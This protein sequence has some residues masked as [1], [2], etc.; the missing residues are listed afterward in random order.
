MA[1]LNYPNGTVPIT[2]YEE[3]SP[4]IKF[5][6]MYDS[7]VDDDAQ[8]YTIACSAEMSP[9]KAPSWMWNV[10]L[11]RET[12]KNGKVPYSGG[13]SLSLFSPGVDYY[14]DI[15]YNIDGEIFYEGSRKF[16]IPEEPVT[17][18]STEEVEESESGTSNNS[19]LAKKLE[20]A[21]NNNITP[22]EGGTDST[23][24]AKEM[25]AAIEEFISKQEFRIVKMNPPLDVKRIKTD[26]DVVGS[27]TPETTAGPTGLMMSKV[28]P[29]LNSLTGGAF[30]KLV[31]IVELA[32]KKADLGSDGVKVPI[33]LKSNAGLDSPEGKL[34]VEGQAVIDTPYEGKSTSQGY[35]SHTVVKW[36]P[37]EK[38][39]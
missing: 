26:G 25:A 12:F 5:E 24:Y 31:S 33:D 10:V 15:A 6:W 30:G 39:E 28:K 36:F 7:Q 14:W 17:V 13:P 1:N 38:K 3:S 18:E 8:T 37:G 4:T 2:I 34:T 19:G 23:G 11:D 27:V 20:I 16:N 32:I 21:I 29:I 9:E 22:G 35:A